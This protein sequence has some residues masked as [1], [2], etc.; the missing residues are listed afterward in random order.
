[1]RESPRRQLVAVAGPKGLGAPRMTLTTLTTTTR[2][3]AAC[4]LP[5]FQVRMRTMMNAAP[6]RGEQATASGRG[7]VQEGLG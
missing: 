2:L 6:P 4:L 7:A 3:M 1:M 5:A